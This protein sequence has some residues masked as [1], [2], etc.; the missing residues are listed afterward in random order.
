VSYFPIQKVEDNDYVWSATDKDYEKF[1][2]LGGDSEW[3]D[4]PLE[5]ALLSYYSQ[6]VVTIRPVKAAQDLPADNRTSEIQLA[7][8]TYIELQTVKFLDPGNQN[9]LVNYNTMLK[10]ITDKN[11]ITQAELNAALRASISTAVDEEFNKISFLLDGA[12]NG[13]YNAVLTRDPKTGQYTL[14]YERPSIANDDEK[15][16]APTLDALLIA[17][18]DGKSKSDFNKTTIDAVRAQAALIPAVAKPAELNAVKQ[19]IT[20]F[21]TT[22]NSN[23]F[24]AMANPYAL[25]SFMLAYY[26]AINA[27]SP[28]LAQKL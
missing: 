10:F 21:F 7:A 19:V 6:P 8:W 5:F 24:K 12:P 17:M 18:R 16:T 25:A 2:P 22:P 11:K 23:T 14:Y 28:D 13:S 1:M 4:T 26:R 15:L 20:N 3:I 27:L 9:R